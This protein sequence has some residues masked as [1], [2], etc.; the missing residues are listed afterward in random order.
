MRP[1]NLYLEKD[2]WGTR[3]KWLALL[4]AATLT[5]FYLLV[6]AMVI[7]NAFLLSQILNDKQSV[8]A[9]IK[10][11]ALTLILILAS[12]WVAGYF[13]IDITSGASR[14]FGY[15]S[16]NLLQPFN[17]APLESLYFKPVPL[18][19]R[20]QSF[21]YLGLGL[22]LLVAGAVYQIARQTKR[23]K[24]SVVLP[25]IIAGCG[26]VAVS[27]SHKVTLG[28]QQLFEIP[29][30][31]LVEGGFGIIRAS[32]RMFF[33][34]PYMLMLAAMAVTIRLNSKKTALLLIL[35]CAGIQF[36][37]LLPIYENTNMY[38]VAKPSPLTSGAWDILMDEIDHI[39]LVPAF[40]AKTRDRG[41]YSIND[42]SPWAFLAASHGNTINVGY[43]ARYSYGPRNEYQAR[44]IEEFM[45]GDIAPDSLYVL[46]RPEQLAKTKLPLAESLSPDLMWGLLD[47]YAI[48][49]PRTTS[50]ELEPWPATFDPR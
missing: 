31:N 45:R 3:L 35:G 30:P 43:V 34:I 11:S 46:A 21:S 37:D 38:R 39:V 19:T 28:S 17:P 23:V 32:Y 26:L 25:L 49:A 4:L 41:P 12:M 16:M 44:L 18:A 33:P 40:P 27:L 47:G 15:H 29:L 42:H 9:A 6:M 24:W 48:I 50:V 36:A 8:I 7:F 2:H 14:G 22:M 10:Y 1:F 5:H 13:V 20:G